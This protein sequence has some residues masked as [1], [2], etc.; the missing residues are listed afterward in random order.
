MDAR[1]KEALAAF[2]EAVAE[3]L[4]A[5]RVLIHADAAAVDAV[6]D[7][8]AVEWLRQQLIEAATDIESALLLYVSAQETTVRTAYEH[9]QDWDRP[10]DPPYL[11]RVP[12]TAAIRI[13]IKS[14]LYFLRAYLDRAYSLLLY[15]ETGAHAGRGSSM[16]YAAKKPANPVA[17]ALDEHDPEWLRW[18]RSFRDMRNEVKEGVNFAVGGFPTPAVRAHFMRFSGGDV[19]LDQTERGTVTMESLT[20]AVRRAAQ[21]AS[22]AADRA[23]RRGQ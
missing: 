16:N 11:G 18:F 3:L 15:V 9:V 21:L 10:F 13:A 22:V 12:A 5:V 4:S 1:I 19:A 2:D 14:A 23:A 8:R 17:L 20:V 7:D 6:S